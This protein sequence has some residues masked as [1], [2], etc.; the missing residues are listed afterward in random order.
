MQSVCAFYYTPAGCLKG[1]TCSFKHVESCP[2]GTTCKKGAMCW[3][4]HTND[5]T[6]LKPC[7]NKQCTRKTYP[8]RKYC[9][10]CYVIVLTELSSRPNTTYVK[11]CDTIECTNTTHLK[12]CKS[13]FL[14]QKNRKA[15][16]NHSVQQNNQPTVT[17]KYKEQK[18]QRV[19]RETQKIKQRVPTSEDFPEL[20]SSHKHAQKSIPM[21]PLVPSHISQA[22]QQQI[23]E[24]PHCVSERPHCVSEGPIVVPDLT[25][26]LFYEQFDS[27]IMTEQSK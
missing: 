27:V 4:P 17:K 7:F 3:W 9:K 22:A 14:I 12:Y 15:H 1:T 24:R 21:I 19:N 11:K 10:P 23:S 8:D 5:E 6:S 20:V 18:N 26:P 2:M 13:C 25:H 16:A